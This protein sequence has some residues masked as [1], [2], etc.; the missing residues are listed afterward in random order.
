MDCAFAAS[1]VTSGAVATSDSH[2]TS[3]DAGY[4]MSCEHGSTH[5]GDFRVVYPSMYAPGLTH[6]FL[7]MCVL[8]HA[9]PGL[10]RVITE[11][12]LCRRWSHT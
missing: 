4:L 7:E 3:R 6:A 11:G 10:V 8:E 9:E 12:G 2:Q 5:T 1:V